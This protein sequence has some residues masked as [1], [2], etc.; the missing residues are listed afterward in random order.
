MDH[1]DEIDAGHVLH[2][3]V[4]WLEFDG[5]VVCGECAAM[6]RVSE[7]DVYDGSVSSLRGM[8]LLRTID[9]E[10]ETRFVGRAPE[11]E[12]EDAEDE[13]GEDW[14]RVGER[15]S[16]ADAGFLTG[17]LEN[18]G[19][20]SRVEDG[21]A[22]VDDDAPAG[23]IL[24]P[25]ELAERAEAVLAALDDDEEDP[26]TAT[27]TDAE[28]G[29]SSGGLD[30]DDPFY[31]DKLL[32]RAGDRLAIDDVD[33]AL[34]LL[35]EGLA[36]GPDNTELLE[37]LS[38]ALLAAGDGIEARAPVDRALASLGGKSH[39]LRLLAFW[40]RV[41]GRGGVVFGDGCDLDAA[42]ELGAWLAAR[43]PRDVRLREALAMV[44]R[45]LAQQTEAGECL[46][47]ALAINPSLE[48]LRRLAK[49]IG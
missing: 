24:V 3:P 20:P 23:H 22:S 30:S 21:G 9:P 7:A 25:P 8:A 37:L 36:V 14:V 38:R 15:C 16:L 10:F 44:Y 19:I 29:A 18:D 41:A 28:Q 11:R 12:G 47:E 2:C 6:L 46:N 32:E 39:R 43:R 49:V 42:R 26:V 13:G 31:L 5:G 48:A 40:T 27:S 33:G 4:C 34:T 45:S 1:D 17:E 35:R